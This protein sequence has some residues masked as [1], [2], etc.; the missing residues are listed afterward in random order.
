MS[1]ALSNRLGPREVYRSPYMVLRYDQARRLLVLTRLS[2]HY[3]SI[4]VLRAAFGQMETD[5]AHIWRQK[6]LLLIDARRSPARNDAVF[7]SEFDRLRK[8]FLRDWQKVASIVQSAIGVLQVA[9]HMR[10]D[11]LPIGV[12]TDVSEALA[13]LGVSMPAEFVDLPE[14]T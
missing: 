13:Y 11:E 14:G 5:T 8:H 9:R 12:F 10:K 6:T 4:E 2:E 1:G 7:E 3:P